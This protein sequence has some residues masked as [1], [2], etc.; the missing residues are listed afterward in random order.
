MVF[1]V[2][3]IGAVFLSLP[4]GFFFYHVGVEGSLQGAIVKLGSWYHLIKYHLILEENTR[5]R[6]EAGIV[7][8]MGDDLEYERERG[9]PEDEDVKEAEPVSSVPRSRRKAPEDQG[10]DIQDPVR[11]PAE[12]LIQLRFRAIADRIKL[13]TAQQVY[14]DLAEYWQSVKKAHDA[15]LEAHKS[16]ARSTPDELR[17]YQEEAAHRRKVSKIQREIELE[18]LELQKMKLRKERERMEGSSEPPKG[19]EDRV[20]ETLERQFALFDVVEEVLEERKKEEIRKLSEK[21]T[22]RLEEIE[23]ASVSPETKAWMREMA[24]RSIVQKIQKLLSEE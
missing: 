17:E 8:G 11:D 24:E 1:G 23:R 22:A 4:F 2:S 20:R 15:H 3:W 5:M 7:S 21:L 6:K 19:V 12:N 16:I 10:V 13:R 18:E 9:Q 14:E